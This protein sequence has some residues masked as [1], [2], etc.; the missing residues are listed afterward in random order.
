[1]PKKNSL[2]KYQPNTIYHLYNRGVDKKNIFKDKKDYEHFLYLIDK[3][4]SP[5]PEKSLFTPK[6]LHGKIELLCYTLMPDHFHLL[7]KQFTDKAITQFIRKICTAYSMYFNKR[8]KRNGTLFEGRYRAVIVETNEQLLHLSRYIHLNSHLA[9][10]FT[11]KAYNYSSYHYFIGKEKPQWLNSQLILN[12]F[13]QTQKDQSY[14][15]F[16]L[17]YLNK[18]VSFDKNLIL[19]TI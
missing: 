8:Y 13:N 4:L 15:D 17:K 3:Y 18:K 16:V 19:E 2:K 12:Y 1:M 6:S 10:L 11:V 9:G 5:P 14:E 7:I